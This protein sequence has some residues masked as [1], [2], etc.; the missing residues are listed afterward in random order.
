[1]S[2]AETQNAVRVAASL[3]IDNRQ[4][5]ERVAPRS[6]QME[7]DL[8]V[9]LARQIEIDCGHVMNKSRHKSGKKG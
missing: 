8:I 3:A 1:M 5:Q 7:G 2:P 6:I 4:R 9:V